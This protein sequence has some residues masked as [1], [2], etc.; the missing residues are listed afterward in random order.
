MSEEFF[1]N[2]DWTFGDRLARMQEFSDERAVKY[3]SEI[4]NL[5][6]HRVS[7][8]DRWMYGGAAVVGGAALLIGGIAIALARPHQESLPLSHARIIFG[9]A[10]AAPGLL[11]GG[12]ILYV[13]KKG[14]YGRRLGDVMGVAIAVIFGGGWGMS[15]LLSALESEDEKLRGQLMLVSGAILLLVA[16]CI[17]LAVLQWMHRETQKRLLRIEYYLAEILDSRR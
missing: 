11:L 1:K 7:M 14:A 16:G 2:D 3:R 17:V 8:R 12:W 15:F 5:L 9:V 10:C 6:L 4:E 13:A